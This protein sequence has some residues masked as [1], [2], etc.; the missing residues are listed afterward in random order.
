[1]KKRHLILAAIVLAVTA[2]NTIFYDTYT[3][4]KHIKNGKF[5][6]NSSHVAPQQLFEKT[7]LILNHQYIDKTMNHQDWDYWVEHYKDKIKTK[8]DATVAIETMIA[9]LD[10][11]YTRFMDRSEFNKLGDSISSKIYGIGVNIYSN[12]GKIIVFSVIA[13][14]PAEAAEL[15]AND[16]ILKVNK[17][18]CSGKDIDKVASL[19]RGKADTPVTLEIKRGDEI[20]TKT[21]IRK[22]V[23]INTIEASNDGDIGYIKVNSFLSANMQTELDN[24]LEKTKDTKGLIFDLRGNTG[25]LLN[26]AV[27]LADKFIKEGCIV[28][29]VSRNGREDVLK[30]NPDTTK[31]NKPI[32]IL[33][34]ETSASASEI[35]S[36]AMK[37]HKRAKLIGERTFGKGMVQSVVPLPNE[38]GVN[39]TVAKYLTPLNNDINEKGIEPHIKLKNIEHVLNKDLQLL[40]AKET[41]KVLIENKK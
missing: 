16:I 4:T 10:E 38:T 14:S 29:V 24:A 33:I 15:K 13:G 27:I 40:K 37:D 1:M 34:N 3:K 28:K 17:T 21:I 39:I 7:A 35:F 9:S 12:S 5:L 11:P 2:L 30:A 31:I 18:D 41:L 26:N 6:V 8:E 22:E 19:I 20:F 23:K 25:G 32:V 36:G